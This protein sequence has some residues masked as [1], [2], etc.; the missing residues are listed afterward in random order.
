MAHELD[1]STGRAAVM[2]AGTP[3]WHRLGTNVADAQTSAEAGP[4]QKHPS[5]CTASC[6]G[7]LSLGIQKNAAQQ[8]AVTLVSEYEITRLSATL[9][10]KLKQ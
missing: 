9:A 7:K 6:S 2:V 8:T 4:M 5:A 10:K 3:A 1:V